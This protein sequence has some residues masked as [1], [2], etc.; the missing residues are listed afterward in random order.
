[1]P[2][3]FVQMRRRLSNW[4]ISKTTD[5]S[6]KEHF[7]FPWLGLWQKLFQLRFSSFSFS[8][9]NH[10]I[11]IHQSSQLPKLRI[12]LISLDTLHMVI[13]IWNVLFLVPSRKICLTTFPYKLFSTLDPS[14]L[15]E[16]LHEFQLVIHLIIICGGGGGADFEHSKCFG[17]NKCLQV[18]T[19]SLKFCWYL[20]FLY[21]TVL[22]TD[23]KIIVFLS[24]NIEWKRSCFLETIL[25]T[26]KATVL[27]DTKPLVKLSSRFYLVIRQASQY[28]HSFHLLIPKHHGVFR[29]VLVV[30]KVKVKLL[31]R[32]QL[33]ATPWTIAYQASQFTGFSRQEYWSGL[34]F[35]SLRDL[36]DPGIEPG[37]PTLQADALPSEPPG[38][39]MV[40]KPPA[41]CRR[42]KKF[43]FDPWVEKITWRRKWQLTPVF[44]PGESHGQRSLVGYSP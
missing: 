38:K 39:P 43:R 20:S 21:I 33:F 18:L 15:N 28:R 42:H 41:K 29:V 2:T 17:M 8:L 10:I 6:S 26:Q 22:Y 27:K 16:S 3:N 12:T 34:T 36:P 1:M 14:L 7:I 37:S 25:L 30:K 13:S 4:Q 35:P 31:D 5:L 9:W 19:F 44:L 24:K 11:Q 40:K 23:L 32:V